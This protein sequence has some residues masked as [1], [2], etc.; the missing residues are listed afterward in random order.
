VARLQEHYGQTLR[1][2]AVLE[3]C[4]ANTGWRLT[5]SRR[6]VVE[7]PAKS[8]AE[9]HLANLRTWRH[10]QFACQSFDPSEI[11]LIERS[12][13]KIVGGVENAGFVVNAARQIIA[14]RI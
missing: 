2:G 12:L 4:F 10:D 13:E 7:R 6:H 8:L 1:V 11:D 5:E 3:G 9:L 14:Q